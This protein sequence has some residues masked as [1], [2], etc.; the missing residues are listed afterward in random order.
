[1]EKTGLAELR[2]QPVTRLSGGELQRTFLAQLL[3]QNTRL[4]LLDEPTNHL[5]LVYQKQVFDLIQNWI[6]ETGGSVVSVVHDLSLA[7]LYGTKALLLH[8][9]RM[10]A[11]GDAREVLSPA[12]LDEVY[13]MDVRGWFRTLGEQWK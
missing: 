10:V 6:K 13:E 11:K 5:D 8:K 7:R 2:H 3:C 1:L 4:M 9:G 12:Y